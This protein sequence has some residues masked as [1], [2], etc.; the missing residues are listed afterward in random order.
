MGFN[1]YIVPGRGSSEANSK[2]APNQKK[3][4]EKNAINHM[5]QCLAQLVDVRRYATEIFTDLQAKA[6]EAG[7]RMQNVKERVQKLSAQVDPIDEKFHK[8]SPQCFFESFPTKKL[9]MQTIPYS[10]YF[11]RAHAPA[12]V[13]R[14]RAEVVS[15]P[16][17]SKL[18]KYHKCL[19]VDEDTQLHC[20]DRYTDPRFFFDQWLAEQKE[21]QEKR[22]RRKKRKRKLKKKKYDQPKKVTAFK[23][24][25][26]DDLGREIV[27][28]QHTIDAVADREMTRGAAMSTVNKNYGS[29]QQNLSSYQDDRGAS[30]SAYEPSAY[31][32]QV[33]QPEGKPNTHTGS[34]LQQP[35][36]MAQPGA[37]FPSAPGAPPP[38]IGSP[39]VV[40]PPVPGAPPPGPAAMRSPPRQPQYQQPSPQQPAQ[41]YQAPVPAAPAKPQMPD[42]LKKYAR[43]LKM[44]VPKPAILN[45]MRQ[46]NIDVALF[47]LWLD[48]N[49]PQGVGAPPAGPG[50]GPPP[51]PGAPT[52]HAPP[53]A[54]ALFASIRGGATLKPA[55]QQQKAPPKRGGGLLGAIRQGRNLKSA[56][57]RVLADK[58][59]E[60]NQRELMLKNLRQGIALKSAKSRKLAKKKEEPKDDNN[61]FALMKMR[62]LIQNSDDEGD[63][64]DEWTDSE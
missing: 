26:K 38:Q 35:P 59:A 36:P 53:A 63:S 1:E 55:S 56:E 40:P 17:L 10:G 34:P 20:L 64:D 45:K 16:D 28:K 43:M 30:G 46:N 8:S 57:D 47:D 51:N 21:A 12:P 27:R 18:D 33:D 4:L 22:R 60:T 54:N 49:G 13:D 9:Q 44:R 3:A 37:A 11:V 31:R 29:S 2:E 6:E 61:I 15:V 48:P 62:Q 23:K 19:A 7:A 32:A 39:A 5:L 25:Y 42:D 14:R 50:T 58:P 24:T 52:P 41:P